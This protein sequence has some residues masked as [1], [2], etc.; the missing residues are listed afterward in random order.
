MSEAALQSACLDGF[1][2]EGSCEAA[3]GA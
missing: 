3:A 1:S 2:S